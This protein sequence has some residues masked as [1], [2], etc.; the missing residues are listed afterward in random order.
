MRSLKGVWL[1]VV[2]VIPQGMNRHRQ[3]RVWGSILCYLGAT[4]NRRFRRLLLFS[5]SAYGSSG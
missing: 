2:I 3:N 4:C 1:L 5:L